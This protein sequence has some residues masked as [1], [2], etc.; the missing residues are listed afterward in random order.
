MQVNNFFLI[1]SNSE[2]EQHFIIY[3]HSVYYCYKSSV[4]TLLI[5]KFNIEDYS[6]ATNV[7]TILKNIY[8]LGK[9]CL[10]I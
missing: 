1:M 2:I 9:N 10:Q 3:L 7:M 6:I 4:R 5:I 8:S